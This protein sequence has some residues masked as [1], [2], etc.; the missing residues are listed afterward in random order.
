LFTG[1]VYTLIISITVDP[2]IQITD[3][4]EHCLW[5]PVQLPPLPPYFETD[6]APEPGRRHHPPQFVNS[7]L[8]EVDGMLMS[9][10][11]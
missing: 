5:S 8:F 1:N 6:D 7:R 10:I 2:S 3:G 4:K 9:H 11:I